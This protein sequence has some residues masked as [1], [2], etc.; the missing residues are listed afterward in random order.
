MKASKVVSKL[1][2]LIIEH[3]DLECLSMDDSSPREI[4]SIGIGTSDDG[5]EVILIA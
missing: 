4:R 2:E 1:V 3:K 5:D